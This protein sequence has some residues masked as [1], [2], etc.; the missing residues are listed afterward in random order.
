MKLLA[1]MA[2]AL[3]AWIAVTIYDEGQRREAADA[4][5]KRHEQWVQEA[6]LRE[7]QREVQLNVEANRAYEN[8]SASNFEPPDYSAFRLPPGAGAGDIKRMAT[9]AAEQDRKRRTRLGPTPTP[10]PGA[11]MWE[12]TKV[13]PLSLPPHP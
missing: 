13:N 1:V 9:L 2:V 7:S 11:W 12:K 10:K 3:L 8:A 4:A 5:E 6:P